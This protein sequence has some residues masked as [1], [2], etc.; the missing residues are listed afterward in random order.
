MIS[1]FHECIS[2][3][4]YI[5]YIFFIA[6]FIFCM[7]CTGNSPSS[8][9]SS[10]FECDDNVEDCAGDC[11]G[12]A[13]TDNCGTCDSDS[14]ND[15]VQDCAGTW[16]GDDNCLYV[17]GDTIIVSDQQLEFNYCHPE[18]FIGNSFSF[19]ENLGKIFM[20]EMSATW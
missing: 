10:T 5:I 17:E 19:A 1:F 3:H 8:S 12:N 9:D 15:C 4:R 7:A 14:S 6:I 2:L 13:T 16:G 18:N 20:I 11:G